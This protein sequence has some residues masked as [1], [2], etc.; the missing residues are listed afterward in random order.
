MNILVLYKHVGDTSTATI[1]H[2]PKYKLLLLMPILRL[3]K[4]AEIV[5]DTLSTLTEPLVYGEKPASL[6]LATGKEIP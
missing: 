5:K 3:S 6:T 4:L 1:Q 2:L